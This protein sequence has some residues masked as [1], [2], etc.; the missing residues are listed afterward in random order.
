MFSN[1]VCK[2]FC[3]CDI[4]ALEQGVWEQKQNKLQVDMHAMQEQISI[5]EKQIEA[6]STNFKNQFVFDL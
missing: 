5:A 3:Y 2:L 1:F 6:L 4:C